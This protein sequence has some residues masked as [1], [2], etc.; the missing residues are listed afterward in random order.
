MNQYIIPVCFSFATFFFL[1]SMH[2]WGF[3]AQDV[4]A[5]ECRVESLRV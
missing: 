2:Y 5:K 3:Q 1:S 4:R